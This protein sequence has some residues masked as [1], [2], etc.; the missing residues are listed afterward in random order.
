[1]L[2]RNRALR[3]LIA[4]GLILIILVMSIYAEKVG[5]DSP[6]FSMSRKGYGRVNAESLIPLVEDKDF[7]LVNVHIPFD[8]EIKGT[9]LNIPYNQ[10][11]RIVEAIPDRDSRI[12]IYCRSGSMSAA[13]AKELASLGYVNITELVGGYNAWQRAGGLMEN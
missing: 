9:D 8:G 5:I 1:M 11:N 13:A 4:S 3:K 6:G 2:F 12:V 10:I 7:L